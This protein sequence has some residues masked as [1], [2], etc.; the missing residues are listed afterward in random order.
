M[1][2][3]LLLGGA[4]ASKQKKKKKKK[5]KRKKKRDESIN[6]SEDHSV[7][8]SIANAKKSHVAQSASSQGKESK[9]E[10]L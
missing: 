4:P 10:F 2:Q 9:T 1:E 3:D 6:E 8:Y 7:N 5:R